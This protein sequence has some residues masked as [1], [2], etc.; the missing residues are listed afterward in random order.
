MSYLVIYL[1][2]L[3]IAQIS[4]WFWVRKNNQFWKQY[5]NTTVGSQ[6]IYYDDFYLESWRVKNNWAYTMPILL[7]IAVIIIIID[8]LH[9]LI[10]TLFCE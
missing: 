9:D 4:F 10:Y 2:W 7:E 3:C 1:V 6:P 8:Y 5:P